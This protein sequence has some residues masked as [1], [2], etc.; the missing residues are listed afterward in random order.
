M[1]KARVVFYLL[2]SFLLKTAAISAS[3]FSFSFDVF[4]KQ[5]MKCA[6][7]SGFAGQPTFSPLVVSGVPSGLACES[8][9]KFCFASKNIHVGKP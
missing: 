2:I 5:V 6:T 7:S 4:F 8:A 1:G 3:S 9:I